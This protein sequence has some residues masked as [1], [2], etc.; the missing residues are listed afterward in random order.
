MG[1][2]VGSDQLQDVSIGHLG[3]HYT[4]CYDRVAIVSSYLFGGL[5]G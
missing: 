4:V 1:E 3:V 2:E 5:Y